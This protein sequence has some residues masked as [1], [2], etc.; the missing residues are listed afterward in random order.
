MISMPF[1]IYEQPQK[2]YIFMSVDVGNLDA[3]V[4]SIVWFKS[5]I[6]RTL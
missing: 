3:R 4:N 2:N 1:R 6:F 5:Q